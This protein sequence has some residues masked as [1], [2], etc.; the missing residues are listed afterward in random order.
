MQ[1]M[2]LMNMNN[3]L[4]TDIKKFYKTIGGLDELSE[5][6]LISIDE[7]N[8]VEH[9]KYLKDLLKKYNIEHKRVSS[10]NENILEMESLIDE[11]FTKIMVRVK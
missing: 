10:F 5:R 1:L 6:Q 7:I 9:E 8:T 3:E 11:K 4:V 2:E